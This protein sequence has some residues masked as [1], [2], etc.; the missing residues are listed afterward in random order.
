[1]ENQKMLVAKYAIDHYIKSNMNLGIGTG[2][3][4]YYAIKYLSEKL[5]SGNLKNLKLYATSSDS[6]YLLSKEQIPYESNFS[7]LNKNLDIAIDGADEILLEKKS[8][9]K[10]MGGAHLME[11][12]IAYNSETL[13]IIADETK[14]VK[15]LGTKMPIPIEVA[16]N[17]VGFI[18]TR[19]EEMNLD[20][21][22]RV[23]KEKKGPI[24]TDN[25]NYILDVKM[26]VENPEGTEKYF[27][28]FPGI[29]EI[30]IFNHKNTKIV[31]YQNKQIKEA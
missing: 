10:G 15:K 9:I 1:M 31:Y 29:L 21:T 30:G 27:K 28:L 17:A 11:K 18:M 5:K 26:H 2:T 19:L 22:L 24:I 3:T 20:T 4:I 25:N 23:C 12:V 13:L 8:L 14:I 6:K 16:Q 7:K